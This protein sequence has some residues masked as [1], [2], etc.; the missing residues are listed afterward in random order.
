M[1]PKGRIEIIWW[2]AERQPANAP[3]ML[4]VVEGELEFRYGTVHLDWTESGWRIVDAQLLQPDSYAG[5][6][7]LPSSQ[8]SSER[9]RVALLQAGLRL[10]A[11]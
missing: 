9:V 1:Q 2:P 6:G 5:S 8:G 10:A 11:N 7:P 4:A 3:E